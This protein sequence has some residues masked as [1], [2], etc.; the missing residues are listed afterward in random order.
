MTTSATMKFP[1]TPTSI[2]L[3]RKLCDVRNSRVLSYV[4]SIIQGRELI[5]VCKAN[6]FV[7][8]EKSVADATTSHGL[9]NNPVSIAQVGPITLF[10]R[11]SSLHFSK[12]QFES[13]DSTSDA[14]LVKPMPVAMTMAISDLSP[15]PAS[16]ANC[17]V[18]A[19][20]IRSELA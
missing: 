15:V 17:L 6:S 18:A 1:L 2:G 8:D 14:A 16:I 11:K 13:D 4:K 19:M 10:P 9:S 5:A 3:W 12:L 20:Q 7:V